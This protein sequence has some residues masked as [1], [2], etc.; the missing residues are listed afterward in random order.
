LGW[1]NTIARRRS[2]SANSSSCSGAPRYS[3]WLFASRI[4]PDAPERVERVAGLG[5][6]ASDVGQRERG[7]EAE[8]VRV[9]GD[10]RA[11]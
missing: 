2:S 6:R 1:T 3:P 8:A 5:E 10:T 11:Q 9:I 4:T 7:E